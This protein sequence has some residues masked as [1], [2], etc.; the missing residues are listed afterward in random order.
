MGVHYPIFPAL[1]YRETV[2]N[3]ML[4]INVKRI[5]LWEEVFLGTA[6]WFSEWFFFFLKA[7]IHHLEPAWSWSVEK[8]ECSPRLVN[9]NQVHSVF[10]HQ[11][12]QVTTVDL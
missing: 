6:T 11:S 9:C 7:V 12:L 2:Q 1:A 4:K 3:R 8:Q 10:R 5:K